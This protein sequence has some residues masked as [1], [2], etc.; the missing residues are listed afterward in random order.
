MK[1]CINVRD[2]IVDSEVALR[3]LSALEGKAEFIEKNWRSG[4]DNEYIFVEDI[5]DAHISVRPV[6]Q[7]NY[8][9]AMLSLN[10]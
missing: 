6:S 4:E 1:L 10:N 5:T 8:A 7:S 9:K 2:A 3:V